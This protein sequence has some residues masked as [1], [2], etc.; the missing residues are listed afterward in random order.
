MDFGFVRGSGCTHRDTNNWLTASIDG[1]NAYLLIMD[2][3]TRYHW[4]FF[5]KSKCPPTDIIDT[6]L[7]NYG[8]SDCL[9]TMWTNQDGELTGS[10]DFRTMVLKHGYIMETAGTYSSFQ[11]GPAECP[12]RTFVQ[13]MIYQLY[14]TGLP[15]S[16]W[17]FALLYSVHL[18]N[19]LTHT[20]IPVT[21]VEA[22]MGKCPNCSNIRFFYCKFVIWKTDHCP[23]K[24]D[25]CVFVG[26]FLH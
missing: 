26:T 13:I 23:A 7:S 20:H 18:I 6:F 10:S 16:Y 12:H 21:P 19:I 3:S 9:R 25:D 5:T 14:T 17:S 8:I 11:N 15:S 24:L 22:Y 4:I 2:A 1:Y